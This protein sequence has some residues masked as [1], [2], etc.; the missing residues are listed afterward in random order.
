[1]YSKGTLIGGGR[2][3]RLVSDS[4]NRHEH[5]DRE[6]VNVLHIVVMKPESF[7][8]QIILKCMTS[9]LFASRKN[10]SIER[11]STGTGSAR[12]S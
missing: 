12:L 4:S 10:Q 6:I 9:A 7:G 2:D 11:V 8:R 5:E 3:S 1:M